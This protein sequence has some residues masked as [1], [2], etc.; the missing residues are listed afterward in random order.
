MSSNSSGSDASAQNKKDVETDDT[1]GLGDARARA[2]DVMVEDVDG[3]D[4][5]SAFPGEEEEEE[6]ADD[7]PSTLADELE[8]EELEGEGMA[9]HNATP[10]G[11]LDDADE[12]IPQLEYNRPVTPDEAAPDMPPD[13]ATPIAVS[14]LESPLDSGSIPD[15][16][17]SIQGSPASTTSRGIASTPR[18]FPS[19]TAS[20]ALQ[21]FER[22]FEGR[23]ALSPSPS[24]RGASPAF[25]SPHSRQVSLSTQFSPGAS[26]QGDATS[27]EPPQAPWEVVRWTKLRKSTLR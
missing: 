11:G 1:A 21:P 9:M 13:P 19:R 4:Y 22:R 23:P 10:S 3:D 17:P 27:D 15:D 25:L 16:T 5:F 18:K 8:G 26:S 12:D 20:G 14:P 24:S 2:P 7:E 6:E